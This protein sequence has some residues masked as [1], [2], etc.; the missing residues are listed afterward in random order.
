MRGQAREMPTT[1]D[2]TPES[3][4]DALVRELNVI[5]YDLGYAGTR[6]SQLDALTKVN[7]QIAVVRTQDDCEDELKKLEKQKT[8][9]T[10]ARNSAYMGQREFTADQLFEARNAQIADYS[11]PFARSSFKDSPARG[12]GLG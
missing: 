2:S 11:T 8:F 9:I 3:R 1:D 7:K 6:V 12:F 5:L 4:K 10:Y